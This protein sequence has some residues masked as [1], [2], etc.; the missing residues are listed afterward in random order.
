MR[1]ILE[2]SLN[3]ATFVAAPLTPNYTL[4]AR[5]VWREVYSNPAGILSAQGRARS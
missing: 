4:D 3:G 5:N 1:V 2:G